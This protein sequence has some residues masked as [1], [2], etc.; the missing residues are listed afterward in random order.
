MSG[1]NKLCGK[2]LKVVHCMRLLR[3]VKKNIKNLV[4]MLHIKGDGLFCHVSMGQ[5]N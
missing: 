3:K 5:K 2:T 4:Q 1:F